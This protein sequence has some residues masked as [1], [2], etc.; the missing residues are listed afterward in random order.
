MTSSLP[1]WD[2][3]NIYP[4][5]N[6][7]EFAAAMADYAAQID[8][9]TTF[10]AEQLVPAGSDTPQPALAAL[11][12]EYLDRYNAVAELGDT[13]QPYVYACLSTDSRDPWARRRQSELEQISVRLH[14]LATRFQAW[15]GHREAALAGVVAANRTAQAHAF[16]LREI[17]EQSR[18]LMSPA[19]EDLAAELSLSGAK[20]W[21][22]LQLTVTSQLSVD[23]VLDGQSQQMSLPALINLRSHPDPD[24]R[25]R[26]YETELQALASIR[27]P[28]AACLNGI[29]GTAN[30]LNRR[31][32][33]QDALHS[34]L[35]QSRIDRPTLETMLGAIAD[36]LPTFR[37]YFRAKARRLGKERLAWYDLF[38]PTGASK[39]SYTFDQARDFILANF[40]GFDAEL[41]GLAQRAFDQRWIDAEP[42]PGKSG[43]AY[44]TGLDRVRESRIL[45]NFD[46][47]L[48]QVSTV[49][50][51]LG[52]AFHNHC[53]YAA[54]RTPLQSL[55]PMTLAETASIMCET[56]V[57]ESV[58]HHIQDPQEE[59]AILETILTGEAQV[60]V[61]IYSRYLF[62]REVFQRRAAAELSADDLC[63]IM[64]H[65]Q[66]VSYGDGLD[67]QF[68]HPYMWTWKPH[69]YH[70]GSP[71]YN[72]P[73][74]FGLLFATGLYAIYQQRGAAFVPDYKRLLASTGEATAADLAARFSI[75]IR[76]RQFWQDSLAMIGQRINRYCA[77]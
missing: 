22:K 28:L 49:A 70:L 53:L 51:E 25:R 11:V 36:F 58:L 13:L 67:E 54:G 45:C 42:R 65:A 33:R 31:R 40:A 52:H 10:F 7:P 21:S 41:A 30:T 14:Q 17:A 19:E 34:A 69:Y 8:G 18:Y 50:H 57:M 29:K 15:L 5:L 1:R 59:L 75:D 76:D 44:C 37:R 32:G 55:T 61:D 71:F 64:A 16:V 3:S 9:L 77:L 24:V 56:I 68:L 39:T 4:D 6:S 26:A 12:G 63:A 20:A 43:G 35:D 2:L 72:F 38:A 74:A 48:D 46:G 27:E 73:Y 47:S 23:F 60:I 62:E 66:T